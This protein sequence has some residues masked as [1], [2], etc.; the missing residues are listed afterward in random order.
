MAQIANAEAGLA[1]RGKLNDTG[2]RKNNFAATAAPAAATAD[3]AA[4]YEVGS[5]WVDATAKRVY[6]ATDV[7]A[8]A[9]VWD[10]VLQAGV[11]AQAYDALLQSF[12]GLTVAADQ[13]PYFTAP[14][15]VATTKITPFTRKYIG[16]SAGF[17]VFPPGATFT[18]DLATAADFK[19]EMLQAT[20]LADPVNPSLGD[21]GVIVLT[22]GG[23]GGFALTYGTSY[24][25]DGGTQPALV[26]TAGAINVLSYKVISAAPDP[27]Q[28]VLKGEALG[29]AP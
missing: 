27:L 5:I 23:A 26:T 21:G 18:P 4:G 25:F 20:T 17:K 19:G 14:D 16:F 9:A 29:A 10:I 1:V 24:M 28:V 2:I 15:T 13:M 11:D 3:T 12:S 8:G 22:Q 6:V 7:S